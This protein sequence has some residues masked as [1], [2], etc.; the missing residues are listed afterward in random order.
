MVC[1]SRRGELQETF[2]EDLSKPLLS[3]RL[4][5]EREFSMDLLR[6]T[7]NWESAKQE[8]VSRQRL[9]RVPKSGGL[10]CS[11]SNQFEC[12]LADFVLKKD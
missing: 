5:T 12:L 6:R 4:M 8:K 10:R 3:E 9:L 1:K 2:C 7:T 11:L